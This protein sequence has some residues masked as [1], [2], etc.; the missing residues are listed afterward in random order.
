MHDKL[1]TR[2][3]LINLLIPSFAP[4]CRRLT[5]GKGFLESLLEPNVEVI[6]APIERITRSGVDVAAAQSQSTSPSIDVDVLV[7]A[8]GYNVSS[9]PP[10]PVLGRNGQPLTARWS[11]RAESYLSLAVDGFP[12]FLMMF[13]PN[14]AIGFGSLTKILEAEAD[15]IVAAIRKLQREDYDSM[16]PKAARVR[17]FTAYVD[18]YFENTVYQDNCRSWYRRD[19]KIVGL[20]PGSTL[21]ALEALRSPRWE[22]WEYEGGEKEG[23]G[24]SWLGNGRSIT[25]TEG[26]PSWY[27]NPEEVEVPM[28]KTPEEN[29]RYKA[30][31]WSY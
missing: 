20:W 16:E 25:Q 6:S 1:R 17:D 29:P 15:Y 3:D 13:G 27:I 2:P 23:N 18:A 9:P 19:G 26:D 28:E 22:D 5:P 11:A 24:L 8:T 30:R 4:G 31:P 14:S 7:C 21:H 12:N 10:F